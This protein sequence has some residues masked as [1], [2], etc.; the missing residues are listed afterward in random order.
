MCVVPLSRAAV[1]SG[2]ND[3]RVA[4]IRLGS[5]YPEKEQASELVVV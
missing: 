3:A 4:I 5:Q 1:R 2:A